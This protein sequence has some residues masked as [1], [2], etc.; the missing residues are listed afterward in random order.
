MSYNL[1]SA[2][3]NYIA[4][5]L[6]TPLDAKREYSVENWGLFESPTV[7]FTFTVLSTIGYG[8]LS[9]VTAGG[10]VFLIAFALLGVPIVGYTFAAMASMLLKLLEAK[11]VTNLAAV[12]KCF[13][14]YD[15]DNSNTLSYNEFWRALKDLN[16]EQLREPKERFEEIVRRL[17]C[18][19]PS[20]Y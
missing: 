18:A 13:D 19:F 10:K 1:S 20:L 7:L 17:V 8:N 15:V 5:A 14:K 4:D 9:P 16:V 3:L 11:A 6:K 2:D 12:R